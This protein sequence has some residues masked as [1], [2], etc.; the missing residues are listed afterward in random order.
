[1]QRKKQYYS[2]EKIYEREDEAMFVITIISITERCREVVVDMDMNM[3]M[4]DTAFIE[5][6]S[7]YED[8]CRGS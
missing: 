7:D 8:C 3:D 5:D 1:M 4:D 6:D 2:S